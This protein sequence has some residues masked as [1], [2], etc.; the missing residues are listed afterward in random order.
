MLLMPD[1]GARHVNHDADV[2]KQAPIVRRSM[3]EAVVNLAA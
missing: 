2:L 1:A 3:S